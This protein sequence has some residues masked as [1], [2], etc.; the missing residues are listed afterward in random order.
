MIAFSPPRVRRVSSH[1]GTVVLIA[2]FV[3]L[4]VVLAS[5]DDVHAS[6]Q[7]VSGLLTGDPGAPSAASSSGNPNGGDLKVGQVT[8]PQN[9]E[10]SVEDRGT[11]LV[12]RVTL[13]TNAPDPAPPFGWW[14]A[15]LD[16]LWSAL[17]QLRGGGH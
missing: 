10:R 4:S 8:T 16:A 7:I 17:V 11:G 13:R 1:R 2:L 9:P 15:Y 6:Q 12:I 3:C 14:G 5:L